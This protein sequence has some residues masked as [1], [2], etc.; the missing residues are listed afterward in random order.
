MNESR[1][2][3]DA[4]GEVP[5]FQRLFDRP[6]VLLGIGLAVMLVLFTFW[7]LWEVLHLPQATLP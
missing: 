2:A 5:F 1:P 7:G 4:G 3:G 6:F